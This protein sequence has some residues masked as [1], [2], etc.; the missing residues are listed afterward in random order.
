[1]KHVLHTPFDK[2]IYVNKDIDLLL[3]VI[4]RDQSGHVSLEGLV[5]LARQKLCR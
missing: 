4:P 5:P 3:D 2:A 1:M